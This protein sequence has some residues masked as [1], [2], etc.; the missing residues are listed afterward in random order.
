MTRLPQVLR[1]VL[2][3][4]RDG[5]DGAEAVWAEVAAVEAELK[6][7]GR[8]LLRSSGTEPYIRVMVE[9]PTE[10]AAEEAA[11][12]LAAVVSRSLGSA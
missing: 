7:Q 6:G 1:N 10:A 5:L 2:V 4:N 11:T 12:R 3:E 9:A 8:V